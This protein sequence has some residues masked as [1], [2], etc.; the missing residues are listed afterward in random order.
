[1]KLFAA[2]GTLVGAKGK[3]AYVSSF[4]SSAYHLLK[5]RS[6]ASLRRQRWMREVRLPAQP[7]TINARWVAM[8]R[9]KL[10]ELMTWLANECRSASPEAYSTSPVSFSQLSA[11]HAVSIFSRHY[12]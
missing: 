7:V 10:H 6:S 1:M 4:R 3:E 9:T 11:Q 2:A 5:W 8:R 12:L